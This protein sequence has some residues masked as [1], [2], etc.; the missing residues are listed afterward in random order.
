MN[1]V[2]KYFIG[3][4]QIEHPCNRMSLLVHRIKSWSLLEGCFATPG[5][6]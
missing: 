1:V 2:D 6:A 5:H 3:L 4:F